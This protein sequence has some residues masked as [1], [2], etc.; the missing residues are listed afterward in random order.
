MVLIMTLMVLNIN[1]MVLF[2]DL[3]VLNM[4]LMVLNEARMVLFMA[5]GAR[6]LIRRGGG[7]QRPSHQAS[8]SESGEWTRA[9]VSPSWPWDRR[10][11]F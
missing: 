10:P 11:C 8:V 2:P 1:L 4:A 6:Y 3:M 9:R 7:A 5:S